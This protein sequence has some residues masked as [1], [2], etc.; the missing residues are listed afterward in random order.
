MSR[1]TGQI[2]IGT[3]GI[4]PFC[5]LTDGHAYFQMKW[6]KIVVTGTGAWQTSREENT[7]TA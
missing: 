5:G 7:T 2:S 6:F 4:T 3:N 1:L